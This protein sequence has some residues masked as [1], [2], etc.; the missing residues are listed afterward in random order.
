MEALLEKI[1]RNTEPKESFCILISER[2]TKILTKFNPLI[3]LDRNKK[4][5]MAL[6]NLETYNSFPNIDETNNNLRYSPD[7]GATWTVIRIPEGSYEI[8]DINEFIQRTMKEQGHYDQEGNAYCLTLQPNTNT[9]KAVLELHPNYW[10]DLRPNN[11]IGSVLGFHK[12]IYKGGYNES[13]N[14]V[15]IVSV[16]SLRVTSDIIGSSYTNGTTENIIYSFFPN[17]GPGYKIIEV[18]HNLVF[19]PITLHTI[20]AMETKLTDQTGKLINLRGEELSIRFV[21]REI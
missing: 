6:V 18:P 5:E 8:I 3:E 11:S 17:V 4:Y 9:L 19:L 10:V 20:S 1:A 16:N 14:I 13:E 7:G 12:Q 21:I 15:Q 2:S